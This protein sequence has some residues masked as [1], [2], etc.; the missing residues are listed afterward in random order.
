MAV[1]A[2]GNASEPC[3]FVVIFDNVYPSISCPDAVTNS[4]DANCLAIVPDFTTN[5]VIDGN[6][7]SFVIT[8]ITQDP[9]AGTLVPAGSYSVLVTGMDSSGAS[10]SCNTTFTALGATGS[11]LAVAATAKPATLWPPNHKMVPVSLNVSVTGGCGAIQ[12]CEIISVT[13]NEPIMSL[14]DKTSPDWQIT[15]PLAVKLRAERPG[16]GDRVYTIS[17]RCTDTGGNSVITLTTVTVPHD[18]G[19]GGL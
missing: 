9:P 19:S 8:N 15:G 17:V 5:I 7:S 18:Q 4:V 10:T 1:D 3:S 14:T 11:P 12:G 16:S 13:S 2:A 6:C